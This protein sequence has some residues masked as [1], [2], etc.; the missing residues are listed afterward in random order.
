MRAER[1]Q[2][3]VGRNQKRSERRL[4]Y[5]IAIGIIIGGMTL[6][7]IQALIAMVAW[8]IYIHDLKVILR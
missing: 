6:A 2:D 3:D 1:D 4:A 7:T 8:Q 5:E